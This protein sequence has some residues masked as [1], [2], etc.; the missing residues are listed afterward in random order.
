[1]IG[2]SPEAAALD[3]RRRKSSAPAPLNRDDPGIAAH[4]PEWR[5][6]HK[7]DAAHL[8]ALAATGRRFDDFDI[9]PAAMRPGP[10]RRWRRR[11]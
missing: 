11:P 1:M 9:K 3:D 6:A 5:Q 4:S 10:T 7:A 2:L 8:A